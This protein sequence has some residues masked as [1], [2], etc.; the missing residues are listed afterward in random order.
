MRNIFT[1]KR[2]VRVLSRRKYE[3]IRNDFRKKYGMDI[4]TYEEYR[5]KV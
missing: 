2:T 1:R 5:K 4:G 3:N